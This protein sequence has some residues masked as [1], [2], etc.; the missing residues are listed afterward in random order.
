MTSQKK[1]STCRSLLGVLLFSLPCY[2]GVWVID[3]G[4]KIKQDATA[5]KYENGIDNPIWAPSQP[6]KLF[7]LKNETVA[8]Q[9]VVEAESSDLNSVTVD[10]ESL[11]GPNGSFI[12]NTS[13]NPSQ[14][15]GRYIERFVEHYFYVERQAG[16][17]WG[18]LFWGPGAEPPDTAWTGWMPDALIPVEIAP[19]WSPYP[20]Q[21]K[22]GQNGVVWIDIT[23]PKNQTPG[24]YTGK[25]IVKNGETL[26]EEFDLELDVID[27]ELPDWPLK[28]MFYYDYGELAR[29]LG[30]SWHANVDDAEEYLWQ[31]FHRHRITPFFTVLTASDLNPKLKKLHGEVYT[32]S[33]AYQGPAE[34]I[35]DDVLSLGT[36]GGYG[37][38]DANDLK[39][40]ENIADLLAAEGLLS[41]TDVFVY[42][43]DEDCGS[44]W[45]QDWKNL[46]KSS[47]N[48]NIDSILVGWTC[49]EEPKKQPVDIVMVGTSAYNPQKVA[50]AQNLGKNVWIYN[51]YLPNSGAY[52][53]DLDAISPRVNGL[54]QAYYNIERWFYW[55]TAFWYDWNN[56]GYGPY[57]PFVESETFHNQWKEWGVGDGVLVYPGKQVDQFK[58]HSIGIDGV[59]A[60]IRLKN[61]RRGIQDAGYY[62]LAAPL[63]AS[64]ANQVVGDLIH[65]ALSYKSK[66]LAPTWPSSGYRFFT[67]RDSLKNIILNATEIKGIQGIQIQ[68]PKTFKLHNPYPNPFNPGT[69]ISYQLTDASEIKIAVF[70]TLGQELDV[71]VHQTQPAGKYNVC[72]NTAEYT[73]GIYLV[74][75][76]AGSYADMIKMTLIK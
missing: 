61:I 17:P 75:M 29:R 48:P 55:E 53:T 16:G 7:S 4:E 19:E 60:S 37:E 39:N 72:W 62:K 57:D 6:V 40:V 65:P 31:L 54:I 34:G 20:M 8:F 10:L 21:I 2:A 11:T 27:S 22:T 49:S 42:A 51:G 14:F 43:T 64:K 26:L 35:G 32:R 13:N 58:E 5:L 56:G 36:Y 41:K 38:P 74:R 69:T 25:I 44:S 50:E 30:G 63:N 46:L 76:Q 68:S 52:V 66:F 67:T 45:G 9:I 73:S 47:K 18:S 1:I 12:Q 33:Y 3:D 71:L 24:Q 23:I 59:L 15:I 28:T 70:N